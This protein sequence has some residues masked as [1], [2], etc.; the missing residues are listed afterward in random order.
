MT[1]NDIEKAAREY[2]LALEEIATREWPALFSVVSR[3]K[4]ALKSVGAWDS[5]P[6]DE[7]RLDDVRRFN[8]RLGQNEVTFLLGVLMEIMSGSDTDK[9]R[10]LASC[11]Y[12]RIEDAIEDALIEEP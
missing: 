8:V 1:N 9:Y 3:A 11:I 10:E 5:K 12:A 4:E 2:R 7:E 6:I